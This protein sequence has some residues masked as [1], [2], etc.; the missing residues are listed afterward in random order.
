M[1]CVLETWAIEI[2]IITI[3]IIIH[4]YQNVPWIPQEL[5]EIIRIS[6]NPL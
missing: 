5:Q 6:K 2:I 1:T 4:F 3:I